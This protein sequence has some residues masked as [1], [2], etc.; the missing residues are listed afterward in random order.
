MSLSPLEPTQQA[1]VL[2][3]EQSGRI[4][5]VP[6]DSQRARSFLEVADERLGE[7]P[8]IGSAVVKHGIAYD[9]AHDVG[10]AF[11]AAYGY[12][13]VNGAGQHAAIGDFLVAVIDA[14]PDAATAANG[15]DRARRSRNQQNYRASP[16]GASQAVGVEQVARTLRAAADARGVG[17]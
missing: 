17:T 2:A 11:L 12:A 13:T 8:L 3:L 15:F 6:A 4:R 9:A 7:L 14:P 16:V 10:E 5:P 1:A